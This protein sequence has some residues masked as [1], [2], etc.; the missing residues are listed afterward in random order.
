MENIDLLFQPKLYGMIRK[1]HVLPT[2]ANQFN[3]SKQLTKADFQQFSWGAL[4]SVRWSKTIQFRERVVEIPHLSIP[5]SALCPTAAITNAF[6]FTA[7]VSTKGFLLTRFLEVVKNTPLRVVFL[8]LFSVF[9]N[10][11]KHNLSF[12]IY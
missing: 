2:A 5:G 12:L 6:R 1:S 4:V 10:V 9:G 7:P 11:A 3:P 8:N